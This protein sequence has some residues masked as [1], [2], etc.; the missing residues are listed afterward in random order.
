[1]NRARTLGL[2]GMMSALSGVQGIL[3]KY[4]THQMI[5]VVA[6]PRIRP[7]RQAFVAAFQRR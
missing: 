5:T 4:Q 1:M 2:Q 6:T 3:V 7:V